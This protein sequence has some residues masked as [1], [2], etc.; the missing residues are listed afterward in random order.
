KRNLPRLERFL[1]TLPSAHRYAFEFRNAEWF[2][3]EAYCLLAKH[4]CAF[5]I[6]D[7]NGRLSP[8]VLTA[9]FVYVRLHGPGGPY[10]GRYDDG[11]L[12]GWA[13]NF[14]GWAAEGKKVYCY[15][16]NDQSGYAAL[17]ALRLQDMIRGKRTS[18]VPG[19]DEGLM[20]TQRGA[21]IGGRIPSAKA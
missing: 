20:T 4:D 15:F 11:T 10:Q 9:D 6:Y 8:K 21:K 3:D 17:N 19:P 7:L 13:K 5:C 2:D 14:T 16:D 18:N 1:T 12:S